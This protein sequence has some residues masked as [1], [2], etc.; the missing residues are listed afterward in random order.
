MENVVGLLSCESM[1]ECALRVLT[2]LGYQ[3]EHA[4]L[5]CAVLAVG[6][7]MLPYLVCGKS[8]LPQEPSDNI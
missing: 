2:S 3:V 6:S 4:A 7:V 8:M 5:R 1:L